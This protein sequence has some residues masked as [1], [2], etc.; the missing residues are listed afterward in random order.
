M[1]VIRLL[2]SGEKLSFA[3][4][5]IMQSKDLA[6]LAEGGFQWLPA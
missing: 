6:L 4:R 2:S 5:M 1:N 3:K